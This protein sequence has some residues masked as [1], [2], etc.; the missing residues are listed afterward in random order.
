MRLLGFV[1]VTFCATAPASAQ[2]A[3][4]DLPV[5]TASL[6]QIDISLDAGRTLAAP[7][8]IRV[9]HTIPREGE[10]PAPLIAFEQL[11]TDLDAVENA[12]LRAGTRGLRLE[13]AKN[14]SERDVLRDTLEPLGLRLRER[15]GAYSVE[16][17]QDG[18]AVKLRKR[19]E[20]AGIDTGAMEKA[21]NGGETVM[22]SPAVT[23]LPSPL[24]HEIWESAIFERKIAPH[25]LFSAIMR[26]RRA[27]LLFYGLLSMSP[28]TRA[29]LA[30]DRPLLRRLY[31]DVA[32]PVAA[33]GSSFRV[34]EDGRVIVPGGAETVEL[35]EALAGE[36]LERSDEF[37]HAIF[38]RSDGRL[39]YL[40]DT[41]AHLDAPHQ[42][43]ALG[44]WIK[45]RGVR[46]ER[47]RALYRAFADIDP[48]WKTLERPF[49]RPLND[50]STMLGL[51]AVG[52]Q[53]EPAAPAYRRFWDR[54]LIG[55][56]IHG[57]GT[58][59]L[60][61]VFEDGVVDA[62]WL[63]EH[64][65]Q[66]LS[67]ERQARLG[68]FAFGQR[69]FGSAPAEELE[70]ALVGIR[71]CARFP[72]LVMT[73]DRAGVSRP[74][75]YALAARRARAIEDV[76]DAAQA[77][78]LLA[79]FQGAL[80]LL[81]RMS[82]TGAIPASRIDALV[83]SLCMLETGSGRYDGALAAWLETTLLSALPPPAGESDRPVETRV[84]RAL[85]DTA[86]ASA[87]FEW[88]GARYIA[89]VTGASLRDLGAVRTKQGGNSLDAVM[90]F[91]RALTPLQQNGLTLET[92]KS[93]TASLKAAGD[94][95]VAARAW[96]DM[97]D[98]VPDVKKL[99]DRA[100]RDL[101]K[102]GKPTDVSKASRIIAPLIGLR[103]YLLG[104]TIVALAY[105]P[106]VGDPR[107][108]LGPETD[109]SHRHNFGLK[110]K[111][112]AP[113]VERRAWLRPGMDKSEN[114]GLA[115]AGSL[116]GL[117]LTL[118]TKR[119]RR[120][121]LDGLPHPPRL[122]SN[123]SSAFVDILALITPR[124]LTSADL[125]SIERAITSGREQVQ[126]A[127]DAASLDR[128]AARVSMSESR[129]QLVAWTLQQE[130]ARVP[131]IFSTAEM[132]W[133][134]FNDR[135]FERLDS[136]GTSFEPQ[137]GC[138]CLRFPTIGTWDRVAG[139]LG[140]RLLGASV[141]DLT[142]RVA[143]HLAALKVPVALFPGVMAMATQDFIDGAPPIYDDDWLGIVGYAG[144]VSRETV[145]DYVAAL[146]AAGPVRPATREAS[147]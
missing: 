91:T 83:S 3:W 138:Y 10:V 139:R 42:R 55:I 101:S 142:L 136:W 22:P 45:D 60:R 18:D 61:D 5:P 56:D 100:V 108:L 103:D 130:P 87:P 64:V 123:D 27:A 102:I 77:V 2:S 94:R 125:S 98:D 23:M 46:L 121:A 50:P 33:F 52:A 30:K 20:T 16:P 12:S 82:R 44:M 51:V 59:E 24:P 141:P 69:A 37:A 119:L 93:N 105:A 132:F 74:A 9:L 96:P 80:L 135:P 36:R 57:A 131:T 134:G 17:N 11:L 49:A 107:E 84:L 99:V 53:G 54:A 62:A 112:G 147:R 63:A 110:S 124:S 137:S 47:F 76:G 145:Q 14:A 41:V 111:P 122:S 21:L 28:E 89:D 116:F 58:R 85:A 114:A 90:A 70:D 15:R 8:A 113:A 104:E 29:F 126:A 32:G 143:E 38:S 128:L 66:G 68:C 7:R 86:E 19:L 43:F 39:A 79:Q 95:L 72:A 40:F 120:I 109:L 1:V 35:W 118:S 71:A 88:E 144:Q 26:D 13:M 140:G 129:R 92:L 25:S 97:A 117:D 31:R 75:T 73:L 67:P 133:L 65:L 78:Q 48:S 81:E 4:F 6:T 127:I 146:V 34:G 106:Y 115:V